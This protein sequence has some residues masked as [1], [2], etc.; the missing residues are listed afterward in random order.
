MGEVFSE[1]SAAD[2]LENDT[3]Q[4]KPPQSNIN[5]K[6]YYQNQTLTRKYYTEQQQQEFIQ[7]RQVSE[8][9]IFY[10]VQTDIAL[11]Y[12]ASEHRLQSANAHVANN[13]QNSSESDREVSYRDIVQEPIRYIDANDQEAV[14][15]ILNEYCDCITSTEILSYLHHSDKPGTYHAICHARNIVTD[16]DGTNEYTFLPICEIFLQSKIAIFR[17]YYKALCPILNIAAVG[18]KNIGKSSFCLRWE[19]NKFTPSLILSKN[20]DVYQ[21]EVILDEMQPKNT[22]I[23]NDFGF[24]YSYDDAKHNT[25]KD[26]SSVSLEVDISKM[27]VRIYD[28]NDDTVEIESIADGHVDVLFLC[29]AIDDKKSFQYLQRYLVDDELFSG[30]ILKVV[31]GFKSEMKNDRFYRFNPKYLVSPSRIEQLAQQY[32]IP[33]FEVSAKTGRNVQFVV[34]QSI[35]ECWL[36]LCKVPNL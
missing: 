1:F 23:V 3:P 18:A 4:D 13:L 15:K 31:V 11:E 19:Q 8:K 17:N 33:Y 32:K 34:L 24:G 5:V 22:V 30:N 25:E 36:N 28:V 12:I 21:K 20:R 26:M 9:E 14:L 27:F 29:F 16:T 7:L 10:R 2:E 35:Y 6:E